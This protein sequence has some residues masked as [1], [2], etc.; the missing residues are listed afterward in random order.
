[1]QHQC[2]QADCL[3]WLDTAAK[4]PRRFG[5]IFLDPP[6]FSTSKRMSDTLDIQ[7]DHVMLVNKTV[8]LLDKN[9]VLLFSNNFSRFKLDTSALSHLQVED[10]TQATI[11]RDFQRNKRIH[12]CW[13][14]GAL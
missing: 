5:L 2:I 11:P 9:G 8:K 6:S 4:Q 7:R 3:R 14:I 13:K 1:S 10:I 12:H